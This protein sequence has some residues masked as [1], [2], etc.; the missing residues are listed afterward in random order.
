MTPKELLKISLA[1]EVQKLIK[2]Y[3]NDME[4]GKHVRMLMEEHNEKLKAIEK[5]S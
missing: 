5:E 2:T 4:L 3:T 1:I